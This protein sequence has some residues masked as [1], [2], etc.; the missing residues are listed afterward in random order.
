MLAIT[1]AATAAP[2]DPAPPPNFPPP[3]GPVDKLYGATIV[4]SEDYVVVSA[5]N[6]PSANP[7]SQPPE[8]IIRNRATGQ[9]TPLDPSF[10]GN[11]GRKVAVDGD[12]VFTTVGYSADGGNQNVRVFSAITGGLIDSFWLAPLG[13]YSTGDYWTGSVVAFDDVI[14]SGALNEEERPTVFIMDRE[15]GDA[16]LRL[17]PPPESEPYQFGAE[18]AYANNKLFVAAPRF[19][20]SPGSPNVVVYDTTTW[21]VQRILPAP[22]GFDSPGFAKKIAVH[23][24]RLA[25]LGDDALY[26]YDTNTYE[27]ITKFVARKGDIWSPNT[28]IAIGPNYAAAAGIQPGAGSIVH[29]IN[30]RN[31]RYVQEIF[32][33]TGQTGVDFGQGLAISGDTLFVGAP[34]S[35]IY[36]TGVYYEYNLSDAR[37]CAGLDV[38]PPY[39]LLTFADIAAFLNAYIAKDPA[40]DIAPPCDKVNVVD[41]S[42][43]VD[44]FRFGCP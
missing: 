43:F 31:G 1:T 8:M 22:D 9:E 21:Q 4:A 16:V 40:A 42:E 14:V 5:H 37:S 39:D 30:A 19:F 28:S 23:G 44:E 34:R 7:F 24:D 12:E 13:N 3:G 27:L 2:C 10:T 6:A 20:P 18:L 41:L 15:S 29:V 25:V 38:A 33:P 17:R 26:L 11:F 32:N 36:P 35:R